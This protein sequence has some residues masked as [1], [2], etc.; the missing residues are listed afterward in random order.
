MVHKKNKLR[1]FWLGK[2]MTMFWTRDF[3]CMILNDKLH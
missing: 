1:K 3:C 2:K